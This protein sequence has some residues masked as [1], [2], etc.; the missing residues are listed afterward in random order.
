M[1][2]DAPNWLTKPNLTLKETQGRKVP[3]GS[4][5]APKPQIGSQRPALPEKDP[6]GSKSLNCLKKR[7]LA[8]ERPTCKVATGRLIP[9]GTKF[10]SKK[11]KLLPKGLVTQVGFSVIENLSWRSFSQ[12]ACMDTISVLSCLEGLRFKV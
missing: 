5:L 6:D 12:V 8:P 4:K 3:R 1:L 9:K 11:F 2:R 7:T 10:G